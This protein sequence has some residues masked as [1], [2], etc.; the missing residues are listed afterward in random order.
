MVIFKVTTYKKSVTAPDEQVDET[1]VDQSASFTP[2]I[3]HVWH[4]FFRGKQLA[5]PELPLVGPE[6]GFRWCL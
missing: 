4:S 2:S 6:G 1:S 5:S 3:L